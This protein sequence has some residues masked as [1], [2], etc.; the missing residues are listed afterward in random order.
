MASKTRENCINAIVNQH[1]ICQETQN[2]LDND[3]DDDDDD[4]DDDE[5]DD[6][7]KEEKL[8]F[9]ESLTRV[10]GCYRP[11]QGSYKISSM[12]INNKNQ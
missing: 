4:D 7:I 6:D 10:V 9:A 8:S 1:N 5:E 12:Q 3:T 2:D 11:L